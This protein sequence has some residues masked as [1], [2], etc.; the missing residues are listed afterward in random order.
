MEVFTRFETET[1]GPLMK[2]TLC[3]LEVSRHG[4]LETELLALLGD[5]NN[6]ECPPFNPV[7]S[8]GCYPC[9]TIQWGPLRM[10][11]CGKPERKSFS[12]NKIFR[13]RGK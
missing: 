13:P 9:Y 5:S 8:A 2:A 10:R 4:L 3:L 6:I 12:V 11:C 7:S 1:G